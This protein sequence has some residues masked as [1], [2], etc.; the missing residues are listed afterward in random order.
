MSL[1]RN[2]CCLKHDAR[3]EGIHEE[4]EIPRRKS[5]SSVP[6]TTEAGANKNKHTEY[7]ETGKSNP[8]TKKMSIPILS[9]PTSNCIEENIL[10]NVVHIAR[11]F[12]WF[13]SF[14]GKLVQQDVP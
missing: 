11:S 8:P 14:S 1:E 9:D 13:P 12:S 4:E 5:N 6:F 10:T 2:G 7:I 3:V